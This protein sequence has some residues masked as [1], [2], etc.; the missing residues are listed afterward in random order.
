MVVL[1]Y[2]RHKLLDLIC[3]N[4][5]KF[6]YLNRWISDINIHYPFETRPH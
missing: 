5:F 6:N 3:K 2:H 4:R 1:I